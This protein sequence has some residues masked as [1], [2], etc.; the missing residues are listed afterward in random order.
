MESGVLVY[1]VCILYGV[2]IVVSDRC[3]QL[4]GESDEH[5]AANVQSGV[6]LAA[7]WP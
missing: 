4:A 3:E 2:Y 7:T 1:S 6:T 5:L